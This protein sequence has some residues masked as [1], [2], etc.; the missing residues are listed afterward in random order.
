MIKTARNGGERKMDGRKVTISLDEY[1]VLVGND[2]RITA[3]VKYI[4][5]SGALV[6]PEMIISLLG[7]EVP[8]EWKRCISTASVQ[9]REL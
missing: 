7:R 2:E 5:R 3:A 4:G 6:D 8:E 9:T 1:N